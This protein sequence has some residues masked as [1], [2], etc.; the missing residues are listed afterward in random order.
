M[1]NM[2][3]YRRHTAKHCIANGCACWHAVHPAIYSFSFLIGRDKGAHRLRYMCDWPT[4][5]CVATQPLCLLPLYISFCLCA[6]E[7]SI[8]EISTAIV[9]LKCSLFLLPTML[10]PPD[11]VHMWTSAC[12]CL[13]QHWIKK[14]MNTLCAAKKMF[15]FCVLWTDRRIR[16]RKP[17]TMTTAAATRARGLVLLYR[18]PKIDPMTEWIELV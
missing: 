12:V 17:L 11:L 10:T 2:L 3:L 5:C 16:F 1:K 13:V 4:I 9:A 18:L 7:S 8:F 14:W 6:R 15:G